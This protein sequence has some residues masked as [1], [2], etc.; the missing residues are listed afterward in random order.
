M[1]KS[2]TAT[3]DARNVWFTR[4]DIRDYSSCSIGTSPNNSWCTKKSINL[5][6]DN[7][8]KLTSHVKSIEN[9][10]G[11]KINVPID[12]IPAK[13]MGSWRSSNLLDPER[14][15]KHYEQLK[16]KRN[17]DYEF[18]YLKSLFI[19]GSILAPNIIILAF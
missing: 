5:F 2:D 19:I 6:D 12:K 15:A 13:I 1:T 17:I 11:N 14:Y 3:A 16:Q 8:F 10:L 7:I 4:L 9:I 18:S